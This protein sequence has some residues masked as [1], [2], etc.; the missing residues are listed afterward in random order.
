MHR[1]SLVGAMAVL[2]LGLSRCGGGSTQTAADSGASAKKDASQAVSDASPQCDA[3]NPC[4]A[5]FDCVDGT[6]VARQIPAD[7]G[8]Q[9]GLDA[10]AQT[11]EDAGTQPGADAGGQPG[12][13]AGGLPGDDAGGQPG[14]DA[15][16]QPGSDAGTKSGSC[17]PMTLTVGRSLTVTCDTK[18]VAFTTEPLN[19]GYDSDSDLFYFYVDSDDG[20]YS[21][22]VDISPAQSSCPT[23][24]AFPIAQTATADIFVMNVDTW[25]FY[26]AWNPSSTGTLTLDGFSFGT[27]K[28]VSFKCANCLLTPETAATPNCTVSG[29]FRE[30]AP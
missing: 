9:V 6:C 25:D 1:H 21:L 12:A 27:T 11:G 2:A 29:T 18:A 19:A 7:A 28:E 15:G 3:A 26:D 16:G 5:N 13:D 23:D 10:G 8:T 22:E 24:Y 4:A 20:L 14:A 30:V 17:G